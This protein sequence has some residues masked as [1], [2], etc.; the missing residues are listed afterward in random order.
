MKTTLLTLVAVALS[1][2]TALAQ[3][4]EPYNELGDLYP[5]F[6]I[7]VSNLAPGQ[8]DGKNENALGDPNGCMGITFTPSQANTRVRVELRCD[9]GL[10]LFEPAVL[11]V[12]ARRAGQ[13]Y[14][15]TPLVPFNYTKL[16]SLR[17]SVTTYVTYSV[18]IDGR[19]QP[20]RTERLRVRSI[21]DCP[22]AVL[23]EDGEETSIAFVFAA[24]VNEDHPQIQ[25]ILQEALRKGYVD[26]FTGYQTGKNDVYRQVA[27]VWRVLQERGIRYSSITAVANTALDGVSSQ[28]VR[29]P[30]ESLRYTQ[31]NCVDGSVLLASILRKI[32][33]NP[34]LVIVPGHM[35]IGF[36][37]N[38]KGN[39]QAYLETT[40]IGTDAR[41]AEV[42][43][44][45]L[46]GTLLGGRTNLK[47]QVALKSFVA[48]LESGHE[49]FAENKGRI[50]GEKKGYAT[51]DIEAARQ[52]G[53][54]PIM[55]VGS[56]PPGR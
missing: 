38:Q 55:Y 18:T 32:D 53:I 30:D 3:R 13:E 45:R 49:T 47:A 39:E 19:R 21:N 17:Q 28:H 20:P 4:W 23:G 51:V 6:A 14:L 15:I 10:K 41:G 25:E 34:V 22:F 33:L 43:N 37:L 5:S 42:R 31:A 2:L 48:A 8:N 54:A 16:A 26:S 1:A 36:D 56:V 7:A 35:F 11:D 50:Y 27:A 29:L 12:V 52:A 44:N 9:N 46:Y 40:L 24:Y